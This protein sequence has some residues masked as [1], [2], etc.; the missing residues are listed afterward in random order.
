M[1]RLASDVVDDVLPLGLTNSE[2]GYN[3]AAMRMA[4]VPR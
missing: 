4:T 1:F 3:L 2:R